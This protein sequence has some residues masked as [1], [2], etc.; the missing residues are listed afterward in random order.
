MRIRS[1]LDRKHR[2]IQVVTKI[3]P[4]GPDRCPIAYT[5][6]DRMRHI[7]EVASRKSREVA[8][9][10]DIFLLP[11]QDVGPHVF[12]GIEYVSV[13]VECYKAE[14]LLRERKCNRREAQFYVVDEHRITA[15]WPAR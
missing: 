8:A 12:R 1:L 13:I 5:R 15:Q 6:T 11:T 7:T 4:N 3:N 9:G 10:S 2:W 14:V